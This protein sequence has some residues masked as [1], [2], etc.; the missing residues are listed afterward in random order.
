VDNVGPSRVPGSGVSV[1]YPQ[2][3]DQP[4][5]PEHQAVTSP[6]VP[7]QRPGESSATPPGSSIS[8]A[9]RKRRNW[10]LI[11]AATAAAIST[12]CAAGSLT[13]YL[14][15]DRST[16]PD[17]GTP[18]IAVRQYLTAYLGD[19]DSNRAALFACGGN[20]D[21]PDVKAVREDLVSREKQYLVSI[22]A[23]ADTIRVTTQVDDDAE[24][25]ARLVLTTV[26]QGSSQRAVE[27]WVFK[28]HDDDGWRVCDGHEVS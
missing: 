24:V 19:R 6:V 21:L 14:W 5:Q 27:Q 13:G 8:P 25:S 16:G 7:V 11:I 15:Y 12:L 28:V 10:R 23:S 22:H 4:P 26:V 17:L 2:C 9:P 18:T 3:V 1:R 20:P